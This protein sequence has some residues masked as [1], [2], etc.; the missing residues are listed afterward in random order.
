MKTISLKKAKNL[1]R[2]WRMVVD[3]YPTMRQVVRD[4]KDELLK[5]GF[6]HCV[7]GTGV[8]AYTHDRCVYLQP[9]QSIKFLN[10]WYLIIGEGTPGRRKKYTGWC[11]KVDLEV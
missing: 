6:E 7:I 3:V 9:V 8:T 4:H 5:D 1:K 11:I 2:K 10:G